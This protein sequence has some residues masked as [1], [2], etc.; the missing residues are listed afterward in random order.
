MAVPSVAN[1]KILDK[2][3]ADLYYILK[4]KDNMPKLVGTASLSSQNYPADLDMLCIV[5]PKPKGASSVKKAF[6]DL[7]KRIMNMPNLFFVE[8]KLQNKKVG[9]DIEKH[10]FYELEDVDGSFFKDFYDNSKIELC[11]IDL[12]QY[13]KQEGIFQEVSCIYFFE[14]MGVDKNKYIESLLI[15]QK[16]YFEDGKYYKSLKRFMLA[17]KLQEPQNTNLIIGITKF[18]NSA[19]G[20]VYQKANHIMA[21]QIYIK[22]FGIDDRVKMFIK[23][24]GLDIYDA[25]AL[26][27]LLEDY[28]KIYNDEAKRFYET[29][30]IPIG[31]LMSFQRKRLD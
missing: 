19:A 24:I 7:F 31:H 18:F 8:F 10:K 9:E 17:S 5:K 22:K 6:Q 25:K 4:Y 11:K 16:H 28:A 14:P 12:I 27:K 13:L 21:C 15:D 30:H 26:D 29:F 3:N 23:K 1:E 20:V 2:S